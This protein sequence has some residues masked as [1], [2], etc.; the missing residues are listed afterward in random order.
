M[1]FTCRYA[2]SVL[3][4]L[5]LS[6]H[7]N[8]V[9]PSLQDKDG[10]TA[11][12]IACL[13]SHHECARLLQALHW[14]NE[15][16]AS[17]NRRMREDTMRQNREREMKALYMRLKKEAADAAYDDW[18]EKNN[19]THVGV[20]PPTECETRCEVR[21]QPDRTATC[22]TCSHV[23]SQ[24]QSATTTHYRHKRVTP[25]KPA[26]HQE[27]RNLGSVGK[28]DK[29]YPYANYPPESM[30]S[31]VSSRNPGKSSA[32]KSSSS[33]TSRVASTR[34]RGSVHVSASA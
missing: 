7:S 34:T 19:A 26:L 3:Y 12:N 27:K 18:L 9:R 5:Y 14:A 10:R 30:R 13:H 8:T 2:T 20:R 17:T 11:Y 33:K 28:P 6:C 23:A 29:M 15:K 25:I 21:S 22:S 32:M 1:F 4:L 31:H 24:R 16:D